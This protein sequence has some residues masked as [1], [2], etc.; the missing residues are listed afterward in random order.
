MD[1]FHVGVSAEAFAAALLSQ[2]GCD[3]LVQYGANQP[4]YD[5]VATRGDR[6][7][8]ISV[9]G[10]QDGGWGL[11]QNYKS[12]GV[13]YHE[14][15]E[16]WAADQSALIVYCLVQFKDVQLGRCPRVYLAT[17]SEIA[18][19][20][21]ASR[22]GLGGTILYEEHT[23]VRGAAANSTDHI[24]P[25]WRFSEPRLEEMLQLPNNVSGLL[26]SRKIP[27]SSSSVR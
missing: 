8:K 11:I 7:I 23:Y 26:L 13:T 1:P 20:H 14:A 6:T 5:F 4:E 15:A 24:P 12:E 17:V 2:A 16:R 25:E 10:S 3:V 19:W 18:S 27:S 21:K 22:G 9:K